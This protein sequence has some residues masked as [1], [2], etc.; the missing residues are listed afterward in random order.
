MRCICAAIYH[1]AIRSQSQI[2]IYVSRMQ[3][4]RG[5]LKQPARDPASGAERNENRKSRVLPRRQAMLDTR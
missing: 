1:D 2:S 3:Q 5:C 4:R